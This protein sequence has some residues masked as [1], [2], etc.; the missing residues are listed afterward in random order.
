MKC[1]NREKKSHFQCLACV[2]VCV[3]VC[4][5]ALLLETRTHIQLHI[6]LLLLVFIFGF[7]YFDLNYFSFVRNGNGV[8]RDHWRKLINCC[9]CC[10]YWNTLSERTHTHSLRTTHNRTE[11]WICLCVS[12]CEEEV[13]VYWIFNLISVFVFIWYFCTRKIYQMKRQ[14]KN[15]MFCVCA[16]RR[17]RGHTKNKVFFV[18]IC[19]QFSTSQWHTIERK[20]NSE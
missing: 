10:C 18:T 15:W 20:P 13:M 5:R 2:F 9:C 7:I 16:I 19:Q 8:V 11:M 6:S 17:R 12:V 4:V 3:W 14:H 1:S